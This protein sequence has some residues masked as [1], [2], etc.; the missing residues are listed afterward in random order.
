MRFWQNLLLKG[1]HKNQGDSGTQFVGN[2]LRKE[3]VSIDFHRFA[4]TVHHF[5]PSF[6]ASKLQAEVGSLLRRSPL[7][8]LQ[9]GCGLSR[10]HGFA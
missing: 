10:L 5:S 2:G 1:F 8:T 6:T 4:S 9:G 7:K 3:W